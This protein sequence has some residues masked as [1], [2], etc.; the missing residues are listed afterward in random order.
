[1]I[2]VRGF[3][4]IWKAWQLFQLLLRLLGTLTSVPPGTVVDLPIPP[5]A[6]PSFTLSDGKQFKIE[7]LGVRRTR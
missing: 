2:W 7:S 5:D 6:Q 3:L 1:M 4:D